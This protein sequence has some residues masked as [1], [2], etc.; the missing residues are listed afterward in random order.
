ML[1]AGDGLV[2]QVEGGEVVGGKEGEE[3]GGGL[4]QEVGHVI[5]F[6]WWGEAGF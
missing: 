6:T 2:G 5:E 4:G 1:D 3:V